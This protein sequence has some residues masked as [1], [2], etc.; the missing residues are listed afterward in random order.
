MPDLSNGTSFCCQ[1]CKCRR[2]WL[3]AVFSLVFCFVLFLLFFLLLFC[4]LLTFHKCQLQWDI[5]FAC[6]YVSPYLWSSSVAAAQD[7]NQDNL[8]ILQLFVKSVIHLHL[9]LNSFCLHMHIMLVMLWSALCCKIY[10]LVTLSCNMSSSILPFNLRMKQHW[11]FTL[12]LSILSRSL[13]YWCA[14]WSRMLHKT[15]FWSLLWAPCFIRLCWVCQ[16]LLGLL[17]PLRNSL[18]IEFIKSH[19]YEIT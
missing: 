10:V 16:K 2:C 6:S 1:I 8:A 5:C 7:N 12:I 9:A 15:W 17:P 13:I 14:H 3:A 4:F 11:D 19:R 18:F